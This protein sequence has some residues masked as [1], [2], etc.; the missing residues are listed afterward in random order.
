MALDTPP[1]PPEIDQL[2]EQMKGWTQYLPGILTV[3][4][5]ILVIGLLGLILFR[6]GFF[7][8][9][10]FLGVVLL[11]IQFMTYY[12]RLLAREQVVEQW[13]FMIEG[14]HGNRE[15]VIQETERRIDRSG[16]TDIR[17][18]RKDV[19]PGLL[20]G[21]LGGKRLYLVITN[22]TNV[23]LKPFQLYVNAMDYGIHLHVSWYLV[24]R[25]SFWQKFL[26]ICFGIPFIGIAFFP[27]LVIGRLAFAKNSGLLELDI[28]DEEDL[29][30]FITN[31]HHCVLDAVEALYLE[32]NMDSSTINR[33]TKGFLGIS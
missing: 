27:F 24:Q 25:P 9:L 6:N 26:A 32:L 12:P 11:G 21:A 15:Y 1:R 13:A 10:F 8:G 16:V 5:I 18:E 29:R 14:G 22:T 4:I 23:N 30:A 17:V 33:Q 20:R 3:S 28:F 2:A 19:V 7:G 31:A